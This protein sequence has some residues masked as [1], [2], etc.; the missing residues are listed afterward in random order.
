MGGGGLFS[1]FH[2]PLSETKK[3]PWGATTCP[4][5]GLRDAPSVS[6]LLSSM[7][8]S[9]ERAASTPP[10]TDRHGHEI[11]SSRGSMLSVALLVT[12]FPVAVAPLLCPVHRCVC[13]LYLHT[14][15]SYFFEAAPSGLCPPPI[16]KLCSRALGPP[17]CQ[18]H[19]SLLCPPWM[20][21]Q[22]PPP[23]QCS[24]PLSSLP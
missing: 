18:V 3:S 10:P 5:S 7:L 21:P 22:P 9:P 8:G 19:C 4:A 17:H 14:P 11:L 15:S 12:C 23:S 13:T 2:F 6:S 16:G 24:L 1:S 20:A